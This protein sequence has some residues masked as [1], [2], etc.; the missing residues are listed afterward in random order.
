[1]ASCH[2]TTSRTGRVEIEDQNRY[3]RLG[4]GQHKGAQ[5]LFVVAAANA[6]LKASSELG[7]ALRWTIPVIDVQETAQRNLQNALAR[8]DGKAIY[9]SIEDPKVRRTIALVYDL[10]CN[11]V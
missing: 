7:A 9:Y 2:A 4:D 6:A 10:F 8:R 3:L 1:M 5:H 11:A